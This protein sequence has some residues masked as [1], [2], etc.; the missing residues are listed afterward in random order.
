MFVSLSLVIASAIRATSF[1]N[2]ESSGTRIALACSEI[3]AI[4]HH[5]FVIYKDKFKAKT[6]ESGL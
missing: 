3:Q 6:R 2:A 1:D 4:S 5:T